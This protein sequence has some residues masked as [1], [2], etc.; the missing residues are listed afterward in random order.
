MAGDFRNLTKGK[1]AIFGKMPQKALVFAGWEKRILNNVDDLA[2][3]VYSGGTRAN[4][5]TKGLEA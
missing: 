2:G 5:N 1:A 3:F 4:L